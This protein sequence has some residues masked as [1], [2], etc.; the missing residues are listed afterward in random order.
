MTFDF[1]QRHLVDTSIYINKS[2]FL[3]M[4]IPVKMHSSRC[5]HIRIRDNNDYNTDVENL[6]KEI[7][8]EFH[9]DFRSLHQWQNLVKRLHVAKTDCLR[10]IQSANLRKAEIIEKLYVESTRPSPFQLNDVLARTASKWR[11]LRKPKIISVP[12]LTFDNAVVE[13]QGQ[14]E[15]CEENMVNDD[16]FA[17]LHPNTENSSLDHPIIE[18]VK[19]DAEVQHNL[20]STKQTTVSLP[21][22]ICTNTHKFISPPDSNI[23]PLSFHSITYHMEHMGETMVKE[24]E[25]S[26]TAVICK[27][28]TIS[29][30]SKTLEEQSL[31]F[32]LTNCTSEYLHVRFKYVTN[33]S[34]F[35]KIKILPKI[36]KRL[37]PGVAVVY[38]LIFK[39]Q[40]TER[41]ET[42]LYFRISRDVYYNAPT[43]P[44]LVPVLSKFGSDLRVTISEIVNIPPVYPWHVKMGPESEHPNGVLK[45]C[46]DGPSSYHLHI[47]KLSFDLSEESMMSMR[48]NGFSTE[49]IKDCASLLQSTINSKQSVK[50]EGLPD[51][52]TEPDSSVFME[53]VPENS[54]EMIFSIVDEIVQLALEVF[55]LDRT[56]VFMHRH[57]KTSIPVYFSKYEH[58]GYH[59]S[60]FDVDLI[61]SETK[62]LVMKKTIKVLAEVL[63]H[64]IKIT[65]ILL[66]MSVSPVSYGYFQDQFVVNNLH[67]LYPATIHIKLTTKMK[68]M[69]YI[70][71]MKTVVPAQSSVTF[72]VKFCSRDYLSTKPSEDLAHFTFKI[73]VSGN[74]AVYE[75]VPPIYYELIAPCAMEFKKVYNENYFKETDSLKQVSENIKQH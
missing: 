46:I 37:Y 59:H 73:I 44:L 7:E 70:E 5:T 33:R 45:I 47:H 4:L 56:Y 41:F 1:L 49:E 54:T 29:I 31:L 51:A 35:K 75:N 58:T 24:W 38:K 19:I 39:L 20:D 14:G 21:V 16:E 65:P 11:D 27:P 72:A 15:H 74:K 71:P 63:P 8:S 12:P 42:G 68:K 3:I 30:I 40:T 53:I 25:P 48:P 36:P 10:K 22:F 60:Y 9:I 62:N 13:E 6:I 32:S 67:N 26:T 64:P 18:P 28:A 50:M 52:Q 57:L 61:D 2:V 23:S 55:V 17:T 69:F 34:F 43:E 66:D